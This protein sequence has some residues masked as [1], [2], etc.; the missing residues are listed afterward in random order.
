MPILNREEMN[1]GFYFS[2]LL[3]FVSHVGLCFFV[4]RRSIKRRFFLSFFLHE[5]GGIINISLA[6]FSYV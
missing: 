1:H 6:G 2:I 5:M 3:L 4:S